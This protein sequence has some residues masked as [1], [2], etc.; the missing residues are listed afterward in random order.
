M[1]LSR[2]GLEFIASL[3]GHGPLTLPGV[4]MTK[5]NA[6]IPGF[7]KTPDQL[8]QE[9]NQL[10]SGL[11]VA[12]NL[13]SDLKNIMRIIEVMRPEEQ[14]IVQGLAK[15]AHGRIRSLLTWLAHLLT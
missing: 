4:I 14:A 13:P 10:I 8:L 15:R 6:D 1:R 12:S 7:E 11:Q 2:A 9:K 3:E 5:V